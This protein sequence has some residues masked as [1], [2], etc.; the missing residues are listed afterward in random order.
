MNNVQRTMNNGRLSVLVCMM[1]II[2]LWF[3]FAACGGGGSESAFRH[4]F[5]INRS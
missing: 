5:S 4:G 3:G 1:A 2:A